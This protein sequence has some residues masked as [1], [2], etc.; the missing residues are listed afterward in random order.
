MEGEGAI[1]NVVDCFSIIALKLCLTND[2]P[3]DSDYFVL[4][5]KILNGIIK[6]LNN[7]YWWCYSMDKETKQMFDMILQKLDGM[8]EKQD[9]MGKKLDIMEEKQDSKEIRQDE[10]F[11][12]VKAIEHSNSVHKSEIDNLQYKIAHTEDII[13]KI[14]NVITE[15]RA[16]K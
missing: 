14:G 15:S 11:E 8:E 6:Q 9:S 7:N 4:I 1:V 10:I 16:L 13:N 5:L 2:K 3:H 12:V